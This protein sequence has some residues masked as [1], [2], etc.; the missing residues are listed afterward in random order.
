VAV[1]APLF[2]R[3]LINRNLFKTFAKENLEIA[4]KHAHQGREF[5]IQ[6]YGPDIA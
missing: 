2:R 4:E 6:N 5:C 3:R 1:L